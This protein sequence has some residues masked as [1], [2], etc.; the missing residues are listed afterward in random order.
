MKFKG[1]WTSEALT[2]TINSGQMFHSTV[3]YG[4]QGLV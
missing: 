1:Q 4:N 2:V 3:V